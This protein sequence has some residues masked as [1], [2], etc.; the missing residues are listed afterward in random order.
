[1]DRRLRLAIAKVAAVATLAASTAYII[2]FYDSSLVVG[3][4]TTLAAIFLA[5]LAFALS[6]RIKSLF[7]GMLL[8]IGGILMQVPPALAI[9]AERAVEIPGPIFGVI[10]FTPVIILGV[11]KTVRSNK[12]SEMATRTTLADRQKG[13]QTPDAR[14]SK[15]KNGLALVFTKKSNPSRNTDVTQLEQCQV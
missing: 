13:R 7:V 10:S 4:G 12:N 14:E 15:P 5:V 9:I 8:T 2:G 11:T 3:R 1:M 6:V